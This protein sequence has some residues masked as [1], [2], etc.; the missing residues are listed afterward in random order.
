MI[1]YAR[2]YTPMDGY[3]EGQQLGQQTRMNRINIDAA[4]TRNKAVE[5]A[6]Q[7][8]MLL[9]AMQ[10]GRHDPKRWDR[11]MSQ[12]AEQ[13]DKEAGSLVGQ[14]SPLGARRLIDAYSRAG[15]KQAVETGPDGSVAGPAPRAKGEAPQYDEGVM[16][17]IRAMPREERQ[18]RARQYDFV[19]QSMESVRSPEDAHRM[20]D[21]FQERGVID[22]EQA[23]GFKAVIDGSER[24][25]RAF[26]NYNNRI[27][28]LR[29]YLDAYTVP[30]GIEPAAPPPKILAPGFN[31]ETGRGQWLEERGGKVTAHYGDMPGGSLAAGGDGSGFTG[32]PL[33]RKEV[34][35]MEANSRKEFRA[36]VEAPLLVHSAAQTAYNLSYDTPTDQVA[37]L[38]KFV[39]TLDPG[40]V[41][42]EGEIG[43]VGQTQS[44]IDRYMQMVANTGK[45]SVVTRK[46][47]DDMIQTMAMLDAAAERK[48]RDMEM[49]Q[50]RSM[51]RFSKGQNPIDLASAV[52][53]YWTS[54]SP[55][56]KW[57]DVLKRGDQAQPP[58]S[59][60]RKSAPADDDEVEMTPGKAW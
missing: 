7:N 21:V 26:D 42:R 46:A 30:G 31:N 19:L 2:F 10:I 43:L 23:E 39:S 17:S 12:L 51:Q 48:Y 37:L 58:A 32:K 27:A 13:G 22:P 14:W 11:L 40:S 57:T 54:Q 53:D 44:M 20:L 45:G 38:Y 55:G 1:D 36:N 18:K 24:G 16:A 25:W 8:Q 59:S 3:F 49:I 52:P 33:S 15:G 9:Q 5:D 56:L 29:D 28:E 47:F 41:V 4:E 35:E 50:T 60:L 34:A 6:R